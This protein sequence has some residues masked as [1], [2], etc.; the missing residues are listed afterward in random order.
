M[1]EADERAL[2]GL[3]S[4]STAPESTEPCGEA[5]VIVD[6]LSAA[7]GEAE[8]IQQAESEP[9]IMGGI[10]SVGRSTDSHGEA[11]EPSRPAE[12]VRSE[13]LLRARRQLS[14]KRRSRR[15][16]HQAALAQAESQNEAAS[17][18]AKARLEATTA[19]L[20]ETAV[21]EATATAQEERDA[22]DASTKARSQIHMTL[23]QTGTA[24]QLTEPEAFATRQRAEVE[25]RHEETSRASVAPLEMVAVQLTEADCSVSASASASAAAS[26]STSTS[27][28]ASALN[29]TTSARLL[30]AR[31]RLSAARARREAALAQLTETAVEATATA[32]EAADASP[33]L[34]L[35][36]VPGRPAPS[37]ASRH[38]VAVV[39]SFQSSARVQ[40]RQ[41]LSTAVGPGE[42]SGWRPNGD[43]EDNDEE[44]RV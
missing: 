6:R 32:Q 44:S 34:Q 42:G 8:E 9:S 14:W 17:A 5:P 18:Q 26:T 1:C 40:Q 37:L 7:R 22:V 3:L 16:G 33:E 20:A 31:Q 24:L 41:W 36:R 35:S 19:Q 11:T 25:A 15:A 4:E 2:D 27:A 43:D 38:R 12:A 13:R 21:L 29:N 28:S 10:E 30:D 39:P 23:V